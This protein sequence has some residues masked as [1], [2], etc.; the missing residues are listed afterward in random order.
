MRNLEDLKEECEKVFHKGIVSPTDFNSLSLAVKKSTGRSISVSTLKRIWGYVSYAHTPSYEILSILSEFVGYRDWHDF[1]N[2]ACVT[3]SSDF[4]G[5]EIIK[6]SELQNGKKVRISWKP[7]R[8]CI[9]E[10]LGN[11]EFK[12][13]EAQNSKIIKGDHFSCGVIAKGEPL[14]C[15][16]IRRG[17]A[18][19]ADGYIAGKT[20]G[21]ISLQI[22]K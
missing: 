17:G 9:L 18:L 2:A 16:E 7:D 5:A 4:I 10:Y 21:I 1:V 15:H 14:I 11:S 12:V 20:D 22:M 13:L 3:D 6:S 8:T 19:L